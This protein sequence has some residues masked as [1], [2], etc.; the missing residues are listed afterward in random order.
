MTIYCV[1][2]IVP[3]TKQL[4]YII[5]FRPHKCLGRLELFSLFLKFRKLRHE[6]AINGQVHTAN[7][8]QAKERSHL[9]NCK[10]QEP[11]VSTALCDFL[12]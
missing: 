3:G 4:T 6:R 1:K 7:K 2:N 8:G 9:P 10:A 11:S 12:F 5:L